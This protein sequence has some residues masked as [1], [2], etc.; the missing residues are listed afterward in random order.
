MI[1]LRVVL[2]AG[3]AQADSISL[4]S[5]HVVSIPDGGSYCEYDS[6]HCPNGWSADGSFPF[7]KWRD[8]IL[9]RLNEFEPPPLPECGGLVLCG[10]PVFPC[11][12]VHYDL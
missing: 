1:I 4:D 10:P 6:M 3:L 5:S 12:E 9:E 7:E 2:V 11:Y 8:A